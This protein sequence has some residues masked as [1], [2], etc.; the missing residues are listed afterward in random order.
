MHSWINRQWRKRGVWAWCTLP[1]AL[2]Y[3]FIAHR[4]RLAY[5]TGKHKFFRASV[6]VIVIG[7]IYAGGT[8][9]TPLACAVGELLKQH[10]WQPGLVSRGYGRHPEPDEKQPTTGQGTHLDWHTFGDEPTLIA[11]KT[12]MPISVHRNRALAAQAL[13]TDFPATD[14]I[15]SDDG[16]QHY[17]LDRDFEILVQDERGIGNGFLLPAGPLREPAARRQEVDLVLTRQP[18]TS[19]GAEPGF[20]LRINAFWQP[21]TGVKLEPTEFMARLNTEQPIAAVAGI[22]V[23]E[24]FFKSLADMGVRICQTH[25][26]ADHAAIELD[27]LERLPAKTILITEKDAVKLP[28]CITDR[29]LWVTQTSVQWWHEDAQAILLQRLA[30]AGIK[31]TES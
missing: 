23:P 31:R 5:A 3:G 12:G 9:K 15:I 14:I 27:W 8:G 1:L 2:L 30:K 19:S 6:P 25:S 21:A 22:G 24:R 11:Q 17:G 26:L 4:R 18:L 10:G 20:V 29:R 28:G 16:L 7:N 13:L